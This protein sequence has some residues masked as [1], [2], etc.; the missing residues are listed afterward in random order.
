MK[1]QCVNALPN[2]TSLLGAQCPLT[3]HPTACSA[4]HCHGPSSSLQPWLPDLHSFQED[5]DKS[6]ATIWGRKETLLVLKDFHGGAFTCHEVTEFFQIVTCSEKLVSRGLPSPPAFAPA[7]Y[8]NMHCTGPFKCVCSLKLHNSSQTCLYENSFVVHQSLS[9]LSKTWSSQIMWYVCSSTS[10]TRWAWWETCRH[11]MHLLLNSA[12][13]V[14]V[15]ESK[16]PSG[17]LSH[18]TNIW[19]HSP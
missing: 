11:P 3:N 15:A 10:F 17:S 9:E 14:G 16:N 8:L 4:S 12:V 5:N 13:D 1:K 6:N 19:Q 18:G 2:V 7:S